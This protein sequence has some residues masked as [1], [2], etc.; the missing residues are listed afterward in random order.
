M[1]STVTETKIVGSKLLFKGIFTVSLLYRTADGRCCAASG[2]LPFSQILEVEGAPEGAE[3]SVRLQ[4]TGADLQVDGARRRGP[5]DR[6]DAVPPR[7][8]SAAPDPGTD[9]PQ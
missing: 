9:A 8:S 5:G 1:N 6:G 4:F 7:H 3:P 2:E